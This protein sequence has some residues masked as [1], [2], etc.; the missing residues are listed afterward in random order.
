MYSQVT[1]VNNTALYAC[2]L[3][4]EWILNVLTMKRKKKWESCEVMEVLTNPIVV[5]VSQYVYL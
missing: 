5:I 1:I 3:V 2:K 4:R